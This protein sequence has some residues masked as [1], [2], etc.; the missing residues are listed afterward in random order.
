MCMNE[1][2]AVSFEEQLVEL[3]S[4]VPVDKQELVAAQ[5]LGVTQGFL[6]SESLNEQR[7]A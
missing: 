3:L 5:L 2:N 4:Q 7:S 6:L 1:M